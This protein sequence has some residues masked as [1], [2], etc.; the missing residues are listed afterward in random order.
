[1][2]QKP[3]SSILFI[4]LRILTALNKLV[5]RQQVKFSIVSSDY[6]L[7]SYACYSCRT[8]PLN[9]ISTQAYK[10]KD[11]PKGAIGK[12]LV[13]EAHVEMLLH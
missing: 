9:Y 4:I 11:K 13:S 2:L 5:V 12:A 1:M 7:H 6:V 8:F 10:T 3:A